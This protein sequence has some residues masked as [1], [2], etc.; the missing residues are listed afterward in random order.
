MQL[1]PRPTFLGFVFLNLAVASCAAISGGG[2]SSPSDAAPVET[3]P[4]SDRGTQI[5]ET[6]T[7]CDGSPTCTLPMPPGCGDG[8]NN[9]GGI[10]I[11]DDGNALAGDGCNGA[12]QVEP[13]WTCPAAG[14]CARA[15]VCG[16]S[17]IN[18]GE[19]CDDGNAV[20]GDGCNATCTLQ[21]PGFSCVPGIRCVSTT[22]CGNRRVE[23]G[24]TCDDGN[25]AAGDGCSAACAL[26][27]GWGCPTPGSPCTR[28]ARCGDSV[29]NVPLGEVCDDGN[30]VDGDGCSADC[31]LK[32]AGCSCV[33]G[34]RCVC[35]EV[36]CGNGTIEGAE[37]CDDGNT[38]AGDGCSATCQLERGYVCPLRKAPCIPDCGDGIVIGNEQCDPGA[39]VP[40][41][42]MACS[43][44]CRWNPGW[45]CTG[46]PPTACHVTVCGD[47]VKEG[48]EGCDDRNTMPFDGCSGTCQNEPACATATG[49]CTPRCGDGVLLG[50]AC[51]DGNN[52]GG[53]GCSPTCTV[54]SGFTCARPPLGDR[55]AVPV[56]YRDFL[57]AHVDFETGAAGQ[58]VAVT[59]LVG[60]QLDAEGKPA[61]AGAAGAGN[62]NG[63]AS[64]MQWYRNVVGTNHTTASTLTLW[65]NGAGAYVNRWGANGEQWPLTITA[66]YCGNV[67]SE[68]LDAAGLPIPCTSRFGTTEC[69]TN[70][71][72]GY[73]MVQCITGANSYSATFRTGFLDGN[74]LFFPVDGDTFTPA[75]ERGPA[76]T[77]PPP[78]AASWPMEPGAPAHNFHFTSEVRY[79]FPFEAGRTYTLDF[80]G[81]DDVWVFVNRRLAVDLGGIHT[82]V[83]GTV[84]IS[85]AN[86]FGMTAGSVYEIVVFQAERQKSSSSYKLT[87][88]GFNG[89]V[90]ACGPTCGDSVVTAGEQCDN[91]AMN[92]GGYN[93][94]TAMCRLG[95]YCGD[96]TVTMPNETC[97]N[98]KNEDAYG[99]GSGCAPGCKLPARCGDMLVQTEYGETCDD[100]VNDGRY[101][102]CSAL[103]QRAGYCGDGKTQAPQ[104]TCDDG[105]NDGSYG[106]CGDPT[107][108]LPNCGPA[109]RCGDGVLQEAY[110]EQC[111]PMASNDAT[112]TV[113]CR[114]PGICGDGVKTAPEEC[115]YGVTGNTGAYGGCAPE[116]NRAPYC[117]DAVK[118]GPEECDDG[119]ND[120]TY[121]G[122]SPQC[123][124]AP[125]CGDGMVA[126]GFEQCDL[127]PA[128]GGTSMCSTTCKTYIP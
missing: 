14:A 51:E 53:D 17:T 93:Q 58:A 13:N 73:T 49:A 106:T 76:A 126:V 32:G 100:G 12:C 113:A 20:D 71:A 25:A 87:L 36:R 43:T 88:G 52:L 122:C 29:V 16:D 120:N 4:M 114:R 125:Y 80:L 108:P 9:Q 121:G 123:K 10:E 46:T 104:E 5:A 96:G 103:C 70:V 64:F 127:G 21:N 41:I 116:C 11:C 34:M 39:A 30:A 57:T 92:L 60:A 107:Q 56:V 22:V 75:A 124:R 48:S 72:L 99:A 2:G 42:A 105:A 37:K 23:P 77:I 83:G 66:Y 33:P 35:P 78:Y 54:E 94:C 27:A 74:P 84:T 128:N 15:F 89:A 98:G 59:G 90:S 63:A 24:E 47:G 86:A 55:I 40:S 8:I 111:E 91:G 115:D 112:C 38:A 44:T 109:P 19:V 28:A 7:G 117:G 26:E 65:N 97:D 50:E 119:K 68:M 18:P 62:I 3:G 85:A 45:A 31:K 110:G 82:P 6:R 95:P 1:S 69:D 101:T 67:G 61:F 79:W 102:G 118:N 81:D